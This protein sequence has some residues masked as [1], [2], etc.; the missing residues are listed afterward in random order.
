M[1]NFVPSYKNEEERLKIRKEKDRKDKIRN[2]IA[3]IVVIAVI[4]V[5]GVLSYILIN[6]NYSKYEHY[7]TKMKIYG[8]DRV[9]DDGSAKTREK[10][11]KSEAIKMILSCVYN[12]PD[13]EGIAMSTEKTY[14]N[15]IWVEYAKKQGIVGQ[16]EITEENA[17]D[18]VKYQE[19]L[20]WFYNVKSKILQQTPDTE[21]KVEV[22]DINAYNADQRL[23]I[24]DLINS[25]VIVTNTKNINGNQKL[26]KGKL[27]ELIVNFAEEYNTIT[28]ADA[29]ININDERLPSNVAEYPYTLS[30]ISKDIYELD[31][32]NRGANG[33]ILPVD[34]YAE[35]K[36]YYAQIKD[37]AESYY[38]YLVNVDYNN[39]TVEQ[40]KRRL[41]K[42]ALQEFDDNVLNEY[43][44]YVKQNSIKLTGTAQAQL[45]CIYFD[46][47]DYRVRMKIEMKVESSNTDTNLLFNDALSGNIEYKEKE[48]TLYADIIMAKNENSD[49]LFV[50]E[51]TIETMLVK[52]ESDIVNAGE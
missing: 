43:V 42:Y 18:I 34:F 31:F 47:Q 46:G 9:Y 15:A 35:N 13:I 27:N 32:I 11:T 8:F 23:A 50:K 29:R 40:M 38:T 10:V 41:K 2:T 16:E 28:V 33:F 37:F 7:E 51:G 4:A 3:A 21:A 17:D 44:E 36:Q 14:S 26:F 49:T 48:Y 22:K 45:P 1:E 52:N 19:V 25:N 12:V 20:V 39:I 5:V 30:G 6:L 24:Y